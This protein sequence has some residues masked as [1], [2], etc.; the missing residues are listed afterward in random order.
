MHMAYRVDLTASAAS[1]HRRTA[2]KRPGE[3]TP[4]ISLF[5]FI[6]FSHLHFSHLHFSHLHFSHLHFS[7]FIFTLHCPLFTL[8]SSL[9][10][11]HSSLSTSLKRQRRPASLLLQRQLKRPRRSLGRNRHLDPQ[12]I[13]LLQR[14]RAD[15]VLADVEV[16]RLLHPHLVAGRTGQCADNL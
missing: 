2:G 14:Q 11:V 6:T 9:S 8:H 1:D 5:H 15:G 7:L 16:H 4:P 3:S 13:A 12:L 10:T